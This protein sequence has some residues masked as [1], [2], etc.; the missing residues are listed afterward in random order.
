VQVITQ[1]FVLRRRIESWESVDPA[2]YFVDLF[3]QN[4]LLHL[5][6]SHGPTFRQRVVKRFGQRLTDFACNLTSKSAGRV[7]L[8]GQGHRNSRLIESHNRPLKSPNGI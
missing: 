7:V 4:A 5:A 8:D 2:Q 6:L 1:D 3:G